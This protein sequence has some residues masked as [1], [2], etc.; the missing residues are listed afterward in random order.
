MKLPAPTEGGNFERPPAGMYPAICYRIID[1]G[2]QP[3]DYQ[4][5]R[6]LKHKILISWE[7]HDSEATMADGRPMTVHK[8]YTWSMHEKSS[9]RHAIGSWRGKAL[10]DAE[11]PNFD[12]E[13]LLGKVCYISIVESDKGYANIASVNKPPKGFEAPEMV[14]PKTFLFLNPNEFDQAVYDSLGESLKLTIASS[15]QYKALK[16]GTPQQYSENPADGMDDEVPF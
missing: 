9:L 16:N 2:T 11:I 12:I 3:S 8:R 14:N 10:T 1:L 7:L 5:E 13:S 6:K 4:G 15:P